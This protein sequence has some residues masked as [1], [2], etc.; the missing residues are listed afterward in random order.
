MP[1]VGFAEWLTPPSASAKTDFCLKVSLD[2]PK[3]A[4]DLMPRG[5]SPAEIREK[6]EAMKAKKLAGSTVPNLVADGQPCQDKNR[7][8]S[9]C[10]DGI[11]DKARSE[12]FAWCLLVNGW[13][14][15][16]E[17][18]VFWPTVSEAS[19]KQELEKLKINKAEGRN[20]ISAFLKSNYSRLDPIHLLAVAFA[21]TDIKEMEEATFWY[22]AGILRM[23]VA[24]EISR[25]E[26]RGL[27]GM[28]ITA[29]TQ[30]ALGSWITEHREKTSQ[31]LLNVIEFDRSVP[32]E[33]GYLKRPY[34]KPQKEWP[35]ILDTARS[36]LLRSLPI[37]VN[38]TV[39]GTLRD[40]AAQRP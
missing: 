38:P 3:Y 8:L 39:Q 11:G 2:P 40:E 32:F 21:L 5:S 10:V 24:Q 20:D 30:T 4:P 12:N 29:A 1:S 15:D 34:S 6:F 27:A 33:P 9:E 22:H 14:W 36:R 25:N 26:N 16:N 17:P 18:T 31:I 35:V 7:N 19:V 23:S 28:S 13:T 37:G